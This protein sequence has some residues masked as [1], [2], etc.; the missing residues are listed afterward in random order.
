MEWR[1]AHL[2]AAPN[3]GPAEMELVQETRS[4]ASGHC[5]KVGQARDF[6]AA[7]PYE[8]SPTFPSMIHAAA[9][10]RARIRARWRASHDAVDTDVDVASG[11]H[12]LLDIELVL[13]T[14]RARNKVW[15]LSV[16]L[17]RSRPA[18]HCVLSILCL[19]LDPVGAFAGLVAFVHPLGDDA[20][21]ATTVGTQPTRRPGPGTAPSSEYSGCVPFP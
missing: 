8:T 4:R 2:A 11:M 7:D 15:P 12:E 14:E 20:S 9:G 3:D 6:N 13:A 10:R 17:G 18:R 19:H 1:T 5:P 21:E 16:L